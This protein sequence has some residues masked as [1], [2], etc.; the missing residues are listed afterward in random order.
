MS[1]T[2]LTTLEVTRTHPASISVRARSPHPSETESS[3][4]RDAKTD[5]IELVAV[6]SLK[7]RNTT[8]SGATTPAGNTNKVPWWKPHLQYIAVCS[9]LFLAGWNDGTT[10]P[11]LPKIQSHYHVSFDIE[12]AFERDLNTLR[13][14]QLHCRVVNIYI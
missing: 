5:D 10:G 8:E 3:R 1:Q 11:L 12:Q 13:L 14:G 9:S 6:G 4:E 7:D 2:E